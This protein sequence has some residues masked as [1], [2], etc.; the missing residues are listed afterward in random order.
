MNLLSLLL[1]AGL[2]FQ[3]APADSSKRNVVVDTVV[4][5]GWLREPGVRFFL[6]SSGIPVLT[7]MFSHLD[8][9]SCQNARLGREILRLQ[10]TM[11]VGRDIAFSKTKSKNL[12]NSL[13][14]SDYVISADSISLHVEWLMNEGRLSLRLFEKPN[15]WF[16]AEIGFNNISNPVVSTIRLYINS[17]G[18]Q[19]TL[20]F[21]DDDA[22]KVLIVRGTGVEELKLPY[23]KNAALLT[24]EYASGLSDAYFMRDWVN[25]SLAKD[26]FE[27]LKQVSG[28]YSALL[29]GRRLG[30][31]TLLPADNVELGRT[32]GFEYTYGWD[33][34]RKNFFAYCR[35]G[36][37]TWREVVVTPYHL[38]DSSHV[39][40]TYRRVELQNPFSL[41]V[42][43]FR[44][45][46]FVRNG[47][48]SVFFYNSKNA[49]VLENL[50]GQS[51]YIH[52]PDYIKAEAASQKL[53]KNQYDPGYFYDLFEGLERVSRRYQ[54]VAFK[55]RL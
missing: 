17:G 51:D 21:Q 28:A 12:R 41:E 15:R 10:N 7:Q 9:L 27:S 46:S 19:W 38:N 1:V 37:N 8:S 16:G 50:D 2:S 49:G 26:F 23:L 40:L 22:G 53:M 44:L 54:F 32:Q 29:L 45:S 3:T 43:T 52:S 47:L 35:A 4:V 55:V 42:K 24:R 14:P 18:P 25:V 48:R 20:I 11:A 39:L 5:Q 13:A 34:E 36:N 31:L 30:E 33:R 6:E